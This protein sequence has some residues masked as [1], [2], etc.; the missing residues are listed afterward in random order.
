MT[1]SCTSHPT[2]TS[3]HPLYH[4]PMSYY[5]LARA[6]ETIYHLDPQDWRDAVLREISRIGRKSLSRSVALHVVCR[7][8][9]LF[10]YLI[11]YIP[12]SDKS[13]YTT[14]QPYSLAPQVRAS[15]TPSCNGDHQK[16]RVGNAQAHQKQTFFEYGIV[17]RTPVDSSTSTLCRS[18]PARHQHAG[19]AD[20]RRRF[21]EPKDARVTECG[22]SRR[23]RGLL[24]I[25]DKQLV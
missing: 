16:R 3:S 9:H 5:K 11:K 24:L 21:I 17:H 22:R 14:T 4:R 2:W 10:R 8:F 25:K 20:G 15:S 19:I 7:G 1:T 12:T 6:L 13:I 18:M 23:R